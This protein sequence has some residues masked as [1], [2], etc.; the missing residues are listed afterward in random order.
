MDILNELTL[1]KFWKEQQQRSF[2]IITAF[3]GGF[4]YNVNKQ[5][6]RELHNDLRAKGLV[7]DIIIKGI[8]KEH[9]NTPEEQEVKEE[10]F[11]VFPKI[12]NEGE[13]TGLK[14]SLM[15]L[16]EKYDQDS[17]LF[18]SVYENVAYLIGTSK[19]KNTYPPYHEEV[20]VGTFRPKLIGEFYSRMRG[21]AFSFTKTEDE[22][23][24]SL[25]LYFPKS[26]DRRGE[27][28]LA[29]FLKEK[30]VFQKTL[31]ILRG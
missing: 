24:E 23:F 8:Y 4:T 3:R 22:V 21:K 29:T 5:L 11:I 14:K 2:G 16:G 6:N 28:Y 15:K 20:N 12:G 31:E 1:S 17:I 25:E 7:A 18:K 30:N 10:A 13:L 27:V 9:Y 19:R 26:I